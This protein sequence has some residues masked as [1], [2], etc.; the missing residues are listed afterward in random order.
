MGFILH[1]T[2]PGNYPTPPP[3]FD[4]TAESAV[5]EAM[6]STFNWPPMSPTA[7]WLT[8]TNARYAFKFMY[9]PQGQITDQEENYAT[10]ALPFAAGTNLREKFLNLRVTENVTTCQSPLATLSILETTETV[11]INGLTFLKQTGGDRGAGNIHQWIAYSISQGS[12][13]VN[14][15]FILHSLNPGNY[16]TPP[17]VFDMA[18]ESA[19]F[20]DIVET[21]TWLNVSSTSTATSAFCTDSRIQPLIEQLKQAM[22]QPN[23]TLFASLVSP[24]HGMDFSYRYRTTINYT[25]LNA[26]SVFTDPTVINWGAGASGLPDVGTFAQIVRPDLV[27]VLNSS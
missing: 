20:E 10:I 2:N 9:P 4:M 23:G 5:F 19:V 22:T 17:P 25:T 27:G 7:N 12:T 6:V 18:A 26:H 8:Y 1:S 21:F 14:M 13:C 3:V 11:T 15:D 24:Q 16:P